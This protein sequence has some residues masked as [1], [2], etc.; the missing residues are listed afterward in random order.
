VF[1]SFSRVFGFFHF[2]VVFVIFIFSRVFVFF[3]F[4]SVFGF[5]HFYVVF[6]VFLFSRSCVFTQQ[7]TYRGRSDHVEPSDRQT[8]RN[9]IKARL[10]ASYLQLYDSE[11]AFET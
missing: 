2:Y 10:K 5:L 4:S 9:T 7:A 3:V 11:L 1:S 6:V 8:L